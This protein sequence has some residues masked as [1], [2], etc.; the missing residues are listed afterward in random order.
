MSMH[1]APAQS[2]PGSSCLGWPSGCGT[3][4]GSSDSRP[5]MPP[6][7]ASHRRGRTPAGSCGRSRCGHRRGRAA[8]SGASPGSGVRSDRPW[9]C[10]PRCGRPSAAAAPASCGPP[11]QGPPSP[12]SR[13]YSTAR[14]N[15]ADRSSNV[16]AALAGSS[17][18][19]TT[20]S[21]S[22][23]KPGSS[24]RSSSKRRRKRAV[25]I[26]STS[27]RR[28]AC[29]ALLQLTGAEDVLAMLIQ[30]LHQLRHTLASVRPRVHTIGTRSCPAPLGHPVPGWRRISSP[31]S[32]SPSCRS[33]G[34]R[35]C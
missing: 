7:P 26:A 25:A 28:F 8:A 23:W 5:W 29:P 20:S 17:L 15:I 9:L 24:C 21:S 11:D 19:P 34:S 33:A 16:V 32:P 12:P 35:P 2:R 31:G 10:R 30:T 4:P 6:A 13:A 22:S 18:L 14:S 1:E 3:S 27:L